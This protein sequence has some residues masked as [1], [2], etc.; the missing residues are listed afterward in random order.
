MEIS[1][2]LLTNSNLESFIKS[3][4]FRLHKLNFDERNEPL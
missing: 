2:S 4:Y 1:G 3:K